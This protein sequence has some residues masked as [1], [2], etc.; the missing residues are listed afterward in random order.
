[1]TNHF[2]NALSK[3]TTDEVN[4][5]CSPLIAITLAALEP[6]ADGEAAQEFIDR[7]VA[8]LEVNDH[9]FAYVAPNGTTFADDEPEAELAEVVG[10]SNNRRP[11][12]WRRMAAS[13]TGGKLGGG[14]DFFTPSTVVVASFTPTTVIVPTKN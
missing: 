10:F 12:P 7:Y 13:L 5:L 1:M 2:R 3:L 4:A 11:E 8:A 6:E 14:A 9:N